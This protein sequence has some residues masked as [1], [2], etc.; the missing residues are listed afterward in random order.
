MYTSIILFV[1]LTIP[2]LLTHFSWYDEAHAYTLSQEMNFFNFKQILHQEGHFIIWYLLLMPFAK[3]NFHYP[4]PMLFINWL[5]YFAAL[6]IMWKK[7]P[8]NNVLKLIV[9]FS[10]LSLNYFPIVARCYSIGILG[11]FILATM[12][13][14]QMKR[15]ILYSIMIVLTAHTSLVATAPSV[16]FCMIFIYNLCKYRKTLSVKNI[17]FPLLILAFG[18]YSWFF[19]YLDGY[20]YGHDILYTDFKYFIHILNFFYFYIL[21]WYL[22]AFTLIVIFSNK[23]I[24][25]FTI[26][27]AINFLI[28]FSCVHEAAPHHSIFLITFL[29]I[30]IWLEPKLHK[31]N[32][33][34][35]PVLILFS[36]LLFWNHG[37][38]W[39]PVNTKSNDSINNY[40]TN[41]ENTKTYLLLSS[42]IC[43]SFLPYLRYHDYYV[44]DYMHHDNYEFIGY[45]NEVAKNYIKYSGCDM[46]YAISRFKIN[47]NSKEFCAYYSKT[48]KPR[49]YY[50]TAFDKTNS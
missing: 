34:T 46:V 47:N 27:T 18:I 35:I 15:P 31:I 1:A 2:T 14:N 7:A 36:L 21:L 24:R 13:N 30:S 32:I 45:A 19:P 5:A 4:Y 23:T 20:G 39:Y 29:I 38:L 41:T 43:C 6:I 26:Q 33:K 8:F 49:I 16:S 22:I 50:V 12:Y 11:F 25:F 37:D 44:Y 48:N 10:W 3:L 40:I 9:T 17:V 42:G 28:F